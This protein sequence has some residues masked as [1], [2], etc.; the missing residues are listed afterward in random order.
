MC[1]MR[2]GDEYVNGVCNE[3]AKSMQ[4]VGAFVVIIYNIIMSLLLFNI[5]RCY[6]LLCNYGWLCRCMTG[7][8]M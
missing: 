3:Y 4:Y 2:V 6:C 8:G 5:I 7:L 1:V